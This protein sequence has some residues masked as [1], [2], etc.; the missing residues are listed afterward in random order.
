MSSHPTSLFIWRKIAKQLE[1]MVFEH[2]AELKTKP[3]FFALMETQKV[4][5]TRRVGLKDVLKAYA[6]VTFG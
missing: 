2:V 1:A 5:V 3:Q 6:S 4:I